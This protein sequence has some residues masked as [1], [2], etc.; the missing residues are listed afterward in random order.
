MD[1]FQQLWVK[2]RQLKMIGQRMGHSTVANSVN[3]TVIEAFNDFSN[4]NRLFEI[5]NGKPPLGKAIP[6]PKVKEVNG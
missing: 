6:L 1:F 2:V 4:T 5:E 3:E